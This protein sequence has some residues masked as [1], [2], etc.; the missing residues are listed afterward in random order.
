MVSADRAQAAQHAAEIREGRWTK[1]YFARVARTRGESDARTLVGEHKA[2]LKREGRVAR[3]V[4]SGGDPSRLTILA[5]E[6]AEDSADEAHLLI[7]LDT[8]R[9]HQIRVM[10]ANLGFPLIGDED[11]GGVPWRLRRATSARGGASDASE[12]FVRI[13]LEAVALKVE[14]AT[15][16]DTHRLRSHPDRRGV[17]PRLEAALDAALGA[18]TRS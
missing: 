15:G 1:W 7:R 12:S 14:R 18:S 16:I 3:V 9:F 17:H 13:D 10:C 2:Y 6:D 8:G 5:V 11:Y 4:R